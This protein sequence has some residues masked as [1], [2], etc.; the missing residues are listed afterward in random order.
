[1]RIGSKRARGL[2]E[3]HILLYTPSPPPGL[4][5]GAFIPAKNFFS[6]IFVLTFAGSYSTMEIQV[7]M[8]RLF[9]F[10]FRPEYD[11]AVIAWNVAT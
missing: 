5:M 9:R 3:A 7:F 8:L 11:K 4:L 10:G 6:L 2:Q 1:M